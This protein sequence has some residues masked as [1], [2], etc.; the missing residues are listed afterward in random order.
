MDSRQSTIIS[1][2]ASLIAL[3]FF[4]LCA[5]VGRRAFLVRKFNWN[6]A[7]ITLAAVSACVFSIFQIAAT[8]LGLGLHQL[9][10]PSANLPKLRKLFIASNT[11]YF[12]CNWAVKHALLL[13]YSEIVREKKY[14]GTIWF[15]HFVAFGFGLSSIVVNIFQCRPF[16]K[17]WNPSVPGYCVNVNTFLYFNCAIML[18]T[19]LVLY[20]MPVVFTWHI[21]IR[22]TQRIGINCLFGLGGFVL[23]VSAARVYSIH[24]LKVAYHDFLWWFADA[25]IWSV[26]ENHLA[27][28]VACAPSIKV[29][30]LLLFP[31]LASSLSHAF[32]KFSSSG[33]G[34]RSRKNSS[35]PTQPSDVKT[36]TSHKSDTLE[37][38]KSDTSGIQKS[39]TL[40]LNLSQLTAPLPSPALTTKSGTSR[41]S[42]NFAKWFRDSVTSPLSPRGFGGFWKDDSDGMERGL[43]Y[44]DDTL[45]SPT[46]LKGSKW[47]EMQDTCKGRPKRESEEME[48]EMDMYKDIRVDRSVSVESGR[49]SEVSN[50]GMF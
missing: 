9:D 30:A 50:G 21:Q 11:F 28:V 23:A 3:T 33:S 47:V 46:S 40:K 5:R 2:N 37:T 17:A 7:L 34:S 43:V 18:A 42:R 49:R 25:M 10:I 16:H 14:Q 44:P 15:M 39:D 24:M 29:I 6:D 4:S 31:R 1:L 27:L 41:A 38:R 32:S 45:V 8:V 48:M 13:F 35:D 12:L 26:L 19:D 36:G 20:I 22:R